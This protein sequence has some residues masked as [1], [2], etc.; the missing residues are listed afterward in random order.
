MMDRRQ[1]LKTLA[2]LG[3]LGLGGASFRIDA[4]GRPEPERLAL[5]EGFD[6]IDHFDVTHKLR[7][8]GRFPIP[9]PSLRKDVVIVGGGISGL[10]ALHRLGEFDALLVEKE[11]EVGGNSRRRQSRGIHYPL[12]AIVSQ[13]AVAPF[14]DF[15]HELA[16][17]FER[18]EGTHL[19][20][21]VDGRLV[22]DPLGAGWQKL[23]F[24]RKEREGFRHAGQ[25][26]AA[27][28]RPKEGIFFPRTDNKPAIRQLD[29]I[30]LKQHLDGKAYPGP[31]NHFLNLLLSSRLGEGGDNISAWTG[32]YVLSTLMAPAYTL[33]GGHGAIAEILR[34]RCLK[35]RPGSVL[36]GF[37]VVNVQNRPDGKVWVT[38]ILADGSAQTIEARCAVMAVPKVYAK[39]AVQG[40]M[41]DR[42]ETLGHFHYN[43]YLVAQVEL[44]KRLAPAFEIASANRFS[45]FIVAADWLK[46]NRDPKGSSHLTVYVPYSG[47]AGRVELYGASPKDLAAR[48]VADLHA[49]VPGSPGAIERIHLN[50][51]GHPMV[52]CAPGMDAIVDAAK[53]PFG[54]IVFAHSD[55]FGICGLYS[56]VWTGMEASGDARIIL[57]DPANAPKT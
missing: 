22:A 3:G 11:G 24:T 47:V 54:N 51:W 23:P 52:S 29:R 56:A 9:A 44:S 14:T 4:K 38:G 45:R 36:T 43:A 28:L 17:P 7:D 12:G 13:G 20:Y 33:P 39:H 35:A 26:L 1:A 8:G 30:S 42:A 40:L 57:E 53:Q 41:Q 31:V 2:L 19:A 21:H 5:P 34:D 49:I 55:S 6:E 48:I 50:R 27:Y 16:V 15:F 46:D 32:L 25:D 18:I 10:T 37:T